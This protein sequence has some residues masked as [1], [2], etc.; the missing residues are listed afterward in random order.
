MS[1][2]EGVITEMHMKGNEERHGAKGGI[3]GISADVANA[4]RE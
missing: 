4:R 2:H 1:I 3:G